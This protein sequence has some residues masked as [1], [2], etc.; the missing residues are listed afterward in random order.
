MK[1]GDILA[2]KYR[3]DRVLGQ[4]GMGVVVQATHVQL[5]DRV[6]LK[7][8]LPEVVENENT[9]ARFL[10]EAQAAVRIKSPHVARVVDVGTLESG[11]PYMVMEYLD[12]RDLSA[13]LETEG[14]LEPSVA[15]LYALQACEALAAAH[16]AGVVHRDIKPGNLFL[17]MGPDRHPV[18]KVLDFGISK[19]A[20]PDAPSKLT[21][22]QT[23]MGSPL[24]M[25]PEQ[26]RSARDVDHRTD[27]WSLGVVLFEALTGQMPFYAETM[28]ALCGMV[29]DRDS[30]SPGI[31]QF[32]PE[33]PEELE[34]V[35]LKCIAKDVNKRYDSVQEMAHDLA[36]FAGELGYQSAERVAR[37]LGASGLAM[38]I[39]QPSLH[40]IGSA[41][42]GARTSAP[43]VNTSTSFSGTDNGTGAIAPKKSQTPLLMAGAVVL[44]AVVGGGAWLARGSA[45]TPGSGAAEPP[46]PTASTPAPPTAAATSATPAV[47]A[48]ASASAVPSAAMPVAGALPPRVGGPRPGGPLPPA[49]PPAGK[50]DKPPPPKAGGGSVF[51]DR[52]LAISLA[53]GL[54]AYAEG[55][56]QLAVG[57]GV[58]V[59]L[60]MPLAP[61][62]RTGRR[63]LR[64]LAVRAR[65]L[66]LG[67][68]LRDRTLLPR[69]D[70][71]AG[72]LPDED[73]GHRP[74]Q[75]TLEPTRIVRPDDQHVRVDVGRELH[76]RPPC[77][78][79]TQMPRRAHLV[80]LREMHEA[81]EQLVAGAQ[82]LARPG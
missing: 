46:R 10:R 12:G 63:A 32:K 1:E 6:A 61:D 40:D 36:P 8:L 33:L 52:Q 75:Q 72:R 50:P 78:T 43:R 53:R 69:H 5:K 49:T 45:A 70:D 19:V 38:T 67:D 39:R 16:S 23:A 41:R 31:R 73:L 15:V 47:T 35:V 74:E 71:A 76:D 28:P 34:M 7:F 57:V 3:V 55:I 17:T 60:R 58:R 56:G 14:P 2:G 37:I 66:D 13:V 81:T 82:E 68:V 59:V 51:D 29:L 77:H 27:I 42:V 30:P 22:T 18:I 62:D 64:L 65:R 54:G 25:S 11:S 79:Q 44:A 24:Y 20:D 4:G 48:P 26:M 9:A 80:L 21:Q